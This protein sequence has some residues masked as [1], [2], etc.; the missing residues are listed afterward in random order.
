MP[1]SKSNTVKLGLLAATLIAG[2]ALGT[3]LPD[4]DSLGAA[5][6]AAEPLTGPQDKLRIYKTVPAGPG[7]AG[8]N[9]TGPGRVTGRY[10]TPGN[11]RLRSFSA[12]TF[13]PGGRTRWH[14]HPFGQLLV[15]T[16]G[17]GWVQ[18]EGE[19]VRLMVRGDVVWTPPNVL[20]WHGATRRTGVTH[21]AISERSDTQE[22]EWKQPVTEAEYNGP[23]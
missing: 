3:V 9:F 20:H 23:R 18:A 2:V 10:P 13:E 11:D 5:A 12:V 21:A 22:V 14:T 19:P 1:N 16:D 17:R 4:A 8:E 6:Q 15:V 7:Q